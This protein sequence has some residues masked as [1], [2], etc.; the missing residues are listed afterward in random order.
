MPLRKKEI[1]ITPIEVIS[2]SVNLKD[3]GAFICV[4]VT[5]KVITIDFSKEDPEIKVVS[6]EVKDCI[7]VVKKICI[8]RV[9][10]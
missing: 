7:N 6:V 3:H 2:L 1:D 10:N 5:D 8:S 4:V 9:S